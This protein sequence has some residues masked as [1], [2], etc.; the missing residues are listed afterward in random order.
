LTHEI[1]QDLDQVGR[2]QTGEPEASEI[3]VSGGAP[4]IS[5]QNF[6]DLQPIQ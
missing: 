6:Y 5:K 2:R 4:F 1:L 3:G